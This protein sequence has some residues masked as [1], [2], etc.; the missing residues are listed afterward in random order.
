MRRRKGN[1]YI[2]WNGVKARLCRVMLGMYV[3]LSA[4]MVKSVKNY[5][6][7]MFIRIQRA[8]KT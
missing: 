3:E 1:S 2:E 5:T 4:F 7:F 6:L 8:A